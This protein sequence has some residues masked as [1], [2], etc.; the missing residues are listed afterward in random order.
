VAREQY[1]Q[2]YGTKVKLSGL[3][4]SVDHP[5]LACS[6]GNYTVHN[7]PKRIFS[8]LHLQVHTNQLISDGIIQEEDGTLSLLEIKCPFS[9][10]KVTNTDEAMSIVS[11]YYIIII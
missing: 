2:L 10:M 11:I 5:F 8:F 4:V 3:V 6:P 9:A 1:E 7:L